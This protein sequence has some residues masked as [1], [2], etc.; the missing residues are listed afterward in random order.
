MA[1]ID[2]L[3]GAGLAQHRL[4]PQGLFRL[5]QVRGLQFADLVRPHRFRQRDL[6]RRT[7]EFRPPCSL[8]GLDAGGVLG[9]V[10]AATTSVASRTSPAS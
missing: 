9:V 7:G 1:V 5:G 8:D 3:T 2:P 10:V 6:F 4:T